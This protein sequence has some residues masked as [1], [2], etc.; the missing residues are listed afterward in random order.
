MLIPS[1]VITKE[2]VNGKYK[3]GRISA[4]TQTLIALWTAICI[5]NFHNAL[6]ATI[7]QWVL[8]G[9]IYVLTQLLLHS[10]E[11]ECPKSAAVFS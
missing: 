2:W 4:I 1:T 7:I 10:Q 11:Q 3:G 8:T 9:N 5:T 6:M